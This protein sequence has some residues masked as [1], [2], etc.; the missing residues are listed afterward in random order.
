M[1]IWPALSS[2]VHH[3]AFEMSMRPDLHPS[4]PRLITHDEV[5]D[6]GLQILPQDLVP[7]GE[8]YSLYQTEAD[9]ALRCLVEHISH[10]ATGQLRGAFELC[11]KPKVLFWTF[12]ELLRFGRPCSRNPVATRTVSAEE[13]GSRDSSWP[14]RCRSRL[15]RFRR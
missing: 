15:L 1:R 10:R 7:S 4:A 13:G 3:C 2:C 11:V 14:G 9:V 6:T 8:R 12:G 5:G